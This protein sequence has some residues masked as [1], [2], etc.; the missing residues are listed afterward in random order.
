[1]K[2]K[3]I[4]FLLALSMLGI[5]AVAVPA[6]GD[7]S[8]SI[9]YLRSQTK[10]VK[11]AVGVSEITF[12]SEDFDST[13][14]V[15]DLAY[16][17]VTALPDPEEG[18]LKLGGIDVSLE[19]V[20]PRGSMQ[21]LRFVAAQ[22]SSGGSFSFRGSSDGWTATDVVCTVNFLDRIN[23]APVTAPIELE[24]VSGV[25]ATASLVGEDPEDDSVTFQIVE[26]PEHG[27]LSVS[28]S[29]VVYTPAEGY[30]GR[31]SF[32]YTATDVYG[33]VS[34]TAETTI[35]VDR[36]KV[37]FV[38]ADMNGN[39]AHAAAVKLAAQGIVSHE[40]V[41]GVYYF[42][43]EKAVTRADFTVMLAMAAG[44]EPDKSATVTPFSD[45]ELIPAQ[46]KPYILAAWRSGLTPIG[47][48]FKPAEE[49]TRS[50]TALMIAKLLELNS[51]D[52]LSV[53]ADAPSV[54]K[55]AVGAFAALYENG[56]MQPLDSGL[57][58]PNDTLTREQAAVMLLNVMEYV[59]E[60]DSKSFWDRLFN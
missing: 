18:V 39:P 55:E 52:S 45:D 15:G 22:D 26:Y 31:D 60:K 8:P 43:P 53:F 57:L 11:T 29:K 7:I 56:I 14:G 2:K 38:Y 4:A 16:I 40:N 17:T 46:Q 30:T 23:F 32:S 10:M 58:A 5:F 13:L 47:G 25:S 51:D 41:A 54:P 35:M 6:S 19:Q 48:E 20:I 28:G 3:L 42:S 36:N 27:T 24:T 44:L 37:G 12:S 34:R 1:M 21:Y 59:E 9:T 49:L 33:N 50:E